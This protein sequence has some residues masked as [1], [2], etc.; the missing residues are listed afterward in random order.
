MLSMWSAILG[1]FQPIAEILAVI[2]ILLMVNKNVEDAPLSWPMT[3]LCFAIC[4][5][6]LYAYRGSPE[7]GFAGWAIAIA[8]C[9]GFLGWGIWEQRDWL[10]GTPPEGGYPLAAS[11]QTIVGN[12]LIA[13]A[14]E[15]IFR[16]WMQSAL[17]AAYVGPGGAAVAIFTVNLVF[18]MM[19]GTR[20]LVF[21]LSAGFFGM[22]MSM[23][24]LAS[25]SI[26]PAAITHA[27][28]NILI[29]ISRRRAAAAGAADC[30]SPQT[31]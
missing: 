3:V 9:V 22:I 18:M 2:F 13:L 11:G 31:E 8:L 19:H 25:G 1:S 6:L 24:V 29:G 26:W 14:E 20:G 30:S 16:G 15:L 28:W 4:G 23:A 5:L 10:F 12:I 27:L 21:A 17:M 7:P